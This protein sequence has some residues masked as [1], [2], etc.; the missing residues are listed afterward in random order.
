LIE[1]DLSSTYLEKMQEGENRNKVFK[2]I[3]T[4]YLSLSNY[5]FIGLFKLNEPKGRYLPL[6]LSPEQLYI[7][8]PGAYYRNGQRLI[9][10]EEEGDKFSITFKSEERNRIKLVKDTF[11]DDLYNLRHGW[12]DHSK[13]QYCVVIETDKQEIIIP[14]FVLASVYYFTSASMKRQ[15]FAQNLEGLYKEG[16]IGIDS[17]NKTAKIHLNTN[18]SDDD[19]AD[20]IRFATNEHA[21]RHWNNIV[22]NMRR[23]LLENDSSR[24]GSDIAFVADIPVVEELTMYVRGVRRFYPKIEKE[25]ILV[26]EI[27]IEN[28]SYEFDNVVIE[29]ISHEIKTVNV[30]KRC[31]ARRTT[32]IVTVRVP[33]TALA[34]IDIKNTERHK[35]IHKEIMGVAKGYVD[36][37]E[38]SGTSVP[39][40]QGEGEADI[41]LDDAAHDG[42]AGVRHGEIK[43]P[44]LG[45]KKERYRE[46]T[47]LK[48]FVE[49]ANPLRQFES[50]EKFDL[51]GPFDLPKSS[52][53]GSIGSLWEYYNKEH[54]ICRQY[55]YATFNFKPVQSETIGVC[56]IEI[57]QNRLPSTTSTYVLVSIGERRELTSYIEEF[58]Q[59]FVNRERIEAV[60]EHVES[61]GCIFYRKKHPHGKDAESYSSWRSALLGW[62]QGTIGQ[63]ED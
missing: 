46:D 32:N 34:T 24:R 38:G 13:A 19:A 6:E 48:D 18:A 44:E 14:C 5:K 12:A 63:K 43:P 3:W 21:N 36:H 11:E 41:S 37:R 28:S 35:N 50:V 9:A 54:T 33:T 47:S 1:T 31:K 49:M 16:S 58:T 52:K 23:H 7:Y 40:V 27:L 56:L 55:M 30:T 62:I 22:N 59:K 45:K 57:D 4:Q 61:Q 29:R 42:D 15:L 20:I 17:L 60:K 25:K 26:L 51:Q 39:V 53:Q 10:P 2:L 8:T